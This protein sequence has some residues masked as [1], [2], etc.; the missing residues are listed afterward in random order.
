LT[1]LDCTWLIWMEARSNKKL[2][3]IFMEGASLN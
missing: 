2:L 1:S 3:E